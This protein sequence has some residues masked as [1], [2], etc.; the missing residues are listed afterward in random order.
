MPTD[1]ANP[2]PQRFRAMADSIERNEGG[3]FGGAFVIIPPEGGGDPI[4]TLI[5]DSKQDLAQFWN[6]VITKCQIMLPDVEQKQ[7]A[8]QGFGRR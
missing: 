4:E 1:T 8:G 2:A 5:L 7:R 3:S 6:A